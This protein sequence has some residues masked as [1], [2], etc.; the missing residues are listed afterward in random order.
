MQVKL[1]CEHVKLFHKKHQL[2]RAEKLDGSILNF[3]QTVRCFRFTSLRSSC[4]MHYS[5]TDTHTHT[6]AQ[7]YLLL[8][9]QQIEQLTVK[10]ET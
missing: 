3:T 7:T 6:H 2:T 10:L 5:N 8:I 9:K 1:R 4:F